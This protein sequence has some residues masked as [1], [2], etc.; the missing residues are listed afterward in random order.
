KG[1]KQIEESKID[2]KLK[3]LKME[4]R[5][6]SFIDAGLIRNVAGVVQSFMKDKGFQ[7]ATVT[8]QIVEMPGG[9][10]L[11]HVTFM[12][13][14]RPKI[15]L[16]PVNVIGNQAIGSG[17]LRKQMKENK[18]R[19]IWAR[20]FAGLS[21]YQEGKFDE[22]ADRVVSYYRDRGYINVRV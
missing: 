20:M 10:K 19:I 14:E 3:E 13:E 4:I 1:S 2:E 22:D 16:H 11:V 12:V 18:Q 15:K 21:T 6:D 5:T 7:A 17:A 9:P 8:P